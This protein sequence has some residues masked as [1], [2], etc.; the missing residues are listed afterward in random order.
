[1]NAKPFS[2]RAAA[3]V[4][5]AAWAARCSALDDPDLGSAQGIAP[6]DKSKPG[7]TVVFDPLRRP[8]P[9]IPF[10]NDLALHRR[11]DGAQ[12]VNVSTVSEAAIDRRNREHLN[13]VEGFSGLTPISVSFDGPLDLTT[14][15]D[16]SVFV[17]N[18]QPG[19]GHVG[20]VIPLDLGRGWYPHTA[21]PHAYFPNDKLGFFDSY[22]LPPDNQVD[23]DGDG[24]PDQWIYHYE[25]A[26]HTLDIRPLL[27]LRA[28]E[29]YAV[30]LTR[31]VKG[32]DQ[33][34]RYGPVRSP[35]DFVNHDTQT[36]ALER[37]LPALQKRGKKRGDIAFGWTLTTGDLAR[38]FRALRDGLYGKGPFAWLDKAFAPKINDVYDMEVTFDGD[39]TYGGIGDKP[40]PLV[41]W[42]TT[43]T[44]QGAYLKQIFGLLN[45]FVPAGG[46]DHVSHVVFGDMV[47]PNL[48]STPDNVWHLDTK[49][50][51]IAKDDALFHEK[52]PFLLI[53]PKATAQ[54][55][56]PFP[57]V[58]Y[59]HATGTSR[60]ECLLMADK[61]AQAGIATF[62]IDAVGHGPV[63][64]DAL[65]F[66]DDGGFSQY[67]PIIRSLLPK[68]LYADSETRFPES[69][70]DTEV[71]QALLK[72]GFM[73]Q[74]AVKGRAT[75]DNEDCFTKGGEAY[76]APNAFRLRDAMR[77]TTLDYIV[78]VRMLRA[79][80]QVPKPPTDPKKA[81]KAQLMPSL[82]AGDFDLDGVLDAGGPTVPYFMTGISLGGIH[83]A[84]TS[85]LEPYIVA[86][87]P[88]VPGAGLADI[89]MRTR[90]HGV[91]TPLVHAISG[92]KVVAC[93]EKKDGKP[94][95]Q[96]YLSWN[97][98]SD[99]CKAL[100]RKTYRDDKTGLCRAT[101]VE[102]P[103]FF[104]KV[105][106]PP[107][108]Q[109]QLDNL[110]NG[111]HAQVAV[112]AD[113]AFAVAVQSDKFDPMRVRV[114]AGGKAVSDVH[115]ATPYEGL[116]KE[117]NTPDFRRFVQLAA[118]VL[119]G[120]D[121]ITVADRVI[122]DPI[123]GYA[124]T[125]ML[126]MLAVLDQTVPFTT[127]VT[128][129]R[130]MGLFGRDNLLDPVQ[131]PYRP[132]FEKAI[133]AGLLRGKDVPPPAV[134]PADPNPLHKLCSLV[135][136][137]PG[138]PGTSGICLADVHGK[139][140]YLAQAPKND[141]FPPVP[142]LN[143]KGEPYKGTFTE[144]HKNLM[145]HYFHSL[146][147]QVLDDVCW[148][149]PNCVADKG[150]DKAWETPVGPVP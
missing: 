100:S 8:Q 78:A 4:V 123:A 72:H 51:E 142:G 38:T 136:T 60:I 37:A 135:P 113:G 23:S 12:Y 29:Q 96:V 42:D 13:N 145:V 61:L 20:E 46:F 36:Q 19:G 97:D 34:G 52:V 122:L 83:T 109:V 94:T 111:N 5:V 63:L 144:Y 17:V 108:A 64:A 86:A 28:G 118:N 26:T 84:L 67:L 48:R 112:G 33:Q 31:D 27:P 14:V 74:L 81:T 18:V 141:E 137:T 119:E 110:A 49:K 126:M 128:L 99:R 50:G 47:T 21:E 134:T 2:F 32:W 30:V 104:A 43:Y 77:Q 91:V 66:L 143:S 95:G 57:V 120:A 132:W 131:A 1:M 146:G 62:S 69:M 125:H 80:G 106:A 3:L 88:V 79:L 35:F 140:E 121:A 89:F 9:E 116:G 39:A 107:G 92:P 98:D 7:P 16:D 10:P 65:K 117:R 6:T 138:K 44:L 148:G 147:T 102:V 40:F 41:P 73:Q 15:T 87:A 90:L 68:F 139:H 130:A 93:P 75:D 82:L 150:L 101:A 55:K 103:T 70:S 25:T 45:Q 149:D 127:G 71:L 54:H 129:A 11:A 58:V 22:V 76:Y 124:P 114:F 115:A 59:A 133:A 53:V 24:V 85:P 56:P 105:P